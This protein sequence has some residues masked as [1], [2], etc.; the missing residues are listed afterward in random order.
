LALTTAI[1]SYLAYLLFTNPLSA[2]R[3]ATTATSPPA[4]RS[5]VGN[6]R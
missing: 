3:Q 2:A 1:V 5:R 4:A 6:P